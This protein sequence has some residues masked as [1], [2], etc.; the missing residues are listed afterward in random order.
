MAGSAQSTD[1]SN[2][3]A[4]IVDGRLEEVDV[5][6]HP[7][8]SIPESDL[9]LADLERRRSHPAQWIAYV[10]AVLV[11]IIAPYWVGRTLA[12]Q[13]TAWLVAHMSAFDTRGLVFVSWTVTLVA[14]T[15]L[16]M[17]VVESQTWLWRIVFV[18]G[19]AAEQF[20][21]GLSLLKF[22]FWYSTYVVYGKAAYLANATN[23]GIIA[24]GFAVAVYAVVWVGL[25]VAIRKDSPLNV[26]T[27]SW[28][29]FILFFAIEAIAL[30]VVLFGGLLTT[31]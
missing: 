25:L 10:A 14:L 16:G 1:G 28:A 19:L 8:P 4:E 24:A 5:S 13:R 23:L 11:A 30:L 31:V 22:D 2:E 29:S 26:L 6:K 9:S 15:G 18:V 3:V 27:R 7:T 17:A 20:I 21:A 12:V